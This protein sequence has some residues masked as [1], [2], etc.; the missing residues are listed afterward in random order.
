[1]PGP[2]ALFAYIGPGPGL[3]FLT[4]FQALLGL[5]A[6]SPDDRPA[7]AKALDADRKIHMRALSLSAPEVLRRDFDAAQ[8]ILF[9]A[10]LIF[11]CNHDVYPFQEL[12]F[13]PQ[14]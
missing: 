8:R 2:D 9:H 6:E 1:M 3:E 14:H 12:S 13:R 7:P 5:D 4:S 10:D 11:N